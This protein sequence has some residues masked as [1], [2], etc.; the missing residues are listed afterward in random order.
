MNRRLYPLVEAVERAV[1]YRPHLSTVLRW[2]Q[3]RNRYGNRLKTVV[4]G[5]RRLCSVEAV[6]EYNAANTAAADGQPK[7]STSTQI[8][9]AH[10]AA[11]KELNDLGV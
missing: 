2:A 6:H 10:E 3:R 1:G 9:R 5:G 7:P 11:M 4:V 8:E